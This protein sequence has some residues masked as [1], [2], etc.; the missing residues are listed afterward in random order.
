LNNDDDRQLKIYQ[1]ARNKLGWANCRGLRQVKQDKS[2]HQGKYFSLLLINLLLNY[3]HALIII[4]T[5]AYAAGDSMEVEEEDVSF[6]KYRFSKKGIFREAF[7]FP[8]C[9]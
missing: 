5:Q 7:L 1:F 2:I 4:F 9:C 8:K 6:K 3:L